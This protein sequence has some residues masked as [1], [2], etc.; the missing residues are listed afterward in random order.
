MLVHAP[1]PDRPM[2]RADL[3]TLAKGTYELHSPS[4]SPTNRSPARKAGSDRGAVVTPPSSESNRAVS[5]QSRRHH[6][7]GRRH[8]P[9]AVRVFREQRAR[10]LPRSTA[11]TRSRRSPTQAARKRYKGGTGDRRYRRRQARLQLPSRNHDSARSDRHPDQQ[12]RR[13]TKSE[14]RAHLARGLQGRRQQQPE[15]RLQLRPCGAAGDEGAPDRRHRQHR[16]G[17]RARRPRRRRLQRRQGRLDQPDQG[18]RTRV[19]EVQ[20]PRQ[21]RLSG[22]CAH[23]A[24]ERPRRSQSRACSRSSN[25]GIRSAASSSRSRS[26]T[27]SPSWRPTPHPRSRE[28]CSRSIAGCRPATSSWRGN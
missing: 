16:L 4:R 22:N 18:A 11:A 14:P 13:L 25:A 23:A 28:Q 7:S 2:T 21:H 8:R 15:R 6:R 17:E 20:H 26:R 10:R 5:E 1:N 12:R 24:L 19:R 9:G 27:P 3:M